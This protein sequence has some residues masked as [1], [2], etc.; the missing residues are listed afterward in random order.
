[1]DFGWAPWIVF[2]PVLT[3]WRNTVH[4]TN[5]T[6]ER[7]IMG[8]IVTSP[9]MRGQICL[10]ISALPRVRFY[11]DPVSDLAIF[12][13]CCRVNVKNTRF[14]T[15]ILVCTM[16]ILIDSRP[17]HCVLCIPPLQTRVVHVTASRPMRE[18]IGDL[19]LIDNTCL[20]FKI[21]R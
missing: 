9:R 1:M 17:R 3:F 21:L 7:C 12:C 2:L 13:I 16:Y 19:F 6:I 11:H 8:K 4:L 5:L 15:I 20:P 18:R 14:Y 10:Q